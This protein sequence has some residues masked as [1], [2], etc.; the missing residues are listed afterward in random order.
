[1]PFHVTLLKRTLIS[2]TRI[3]PFLTCRIHESLVLK[4]NKVLTQAH[5]QNKKIYKKF[6]G[7]IRLPDVK[8]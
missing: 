5:T 7:M 8:L 6:E 4:G 1:M 2:D 3:I